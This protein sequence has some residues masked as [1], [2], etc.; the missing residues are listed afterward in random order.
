MI[1]A[2]KLTYRPSKD[3]F[4][5]KFLEKRRS[6]LSYF[7]TYAFSVLGKL[8]TNGCQMRYAQP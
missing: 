6:G 5:S 8:A 3:R 1:A 4:Q 7:L 2:A